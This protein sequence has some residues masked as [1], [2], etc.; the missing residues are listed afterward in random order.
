MT[1]DLTY[2]RYNDYKV[3]FCLRSTVHLILCDGVT[4]RVDGFIPDPDA[5]YC[6]LFL[7]GQ[8]AQTGRL[9]TLELSG[10]N[11]LYLHGG[12]LETDCIDAMH[13]GLR[14]CAVNAAQSIR[15]GSDANLTG[16][17]VTPSMIAKSLYIPDG[18]LR[19]DAI[20]IS[21]NGYMRG[22]SVTVD[23]DVSAN[24]RFEI[25]GGTI[26]VN[27][28][29]SVGNSLS[30][31]WTSPQDRYSFHSVQ[32]GTAYVPD[33]QELVDGEYIYSGTLNSE[34]FAH[35]AGRTLML[36][37]PHDPDE[38]CHHPAV[39]PTWDPETGV[40][41]DGCVEYWTCP[42]CGGYLAWSDY[43]QDLNYRDPSDTMFGNGIIVP[44]FYFD[45]EAF[46]DHET[47]VVT[48][49]M[50]QDA[51]VVIP[52]VVPESYCV[53]K[54]RG[55][56][57]T[58]ISWSAFQDNETVTS[59][60]I[61]DNVQHISFN[62]FTGRWIVEQLDSLDETDPEA[63]EAA[64]GEEIVITKRFLRL[65][66]VWLTPWAA[67][68]EEI[69]AVEDYM[70]SIRLTRDY[71]AGPEDAA[72][73]IPAGRAISTNLNG[74][75]ID[76]NLDSPRADGCVI[77]N[78]GELNIFGG[79]FYL[80]STTENG[81]TFY[82]TMN[83]H[84][85]RITGNTAGSQ[86]GGIL[87]NAILN[88]S[89]K[90]VVRDNSGR[91]GNNIYLRPAE[92]SRY[93]N[94]PGTLRQGAE[95]WVYTET[96]PTE[97]APLV[98][99]SGLSEFDNTAEHFFSDRSGWCAALTEDGEAA[100]VRSYRVSF[101][102]NGGSAEMRAVDVPR[103]SAYVLPACGFTA[104]LGYEF[105][106]WS[107]QIGGGAA[108]ELRP[109]DEIE[110][111]ANT[112]V[113]ALWA[114]RTSPFADVPADA[115]YIDAVCWAAENG[116]TAGTSE[117]TF[118]PGSACTRA[119]ILT[120][121]WRAAGSPAPDG[122]ESPFLDVSADAWY[123]EAVLWAWENG[124]TEGVDAESFAPDRACTRAQIVT[125]LWRL[126]GSPEPIST[127]TGFAD[128]PARAWYA[129]AVAW[130][131]ENGITAGTAPDAFSPGQICTRA[132]AVSFLYAWSR[133]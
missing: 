101:A 123:A 102:A 36:D 120:F 54:M 22:G 84:A 17:V 57:V 109:G 90:P 91:Y 41:T 50:G 29:F 2:A 110:V 75:T 126:E 6:G 118:S 15:A 88:V 58:S 65:T 49:Y 1:Q 45:E 34:D 55:R 103:G 112:T 125:F 117:T 4:L 19:T 100:L 33:G 52:N 13:L 68:Q 80:G 133:S 67:L 14:C 25:T 69:N 21:D 59:V 130:A 127:V 121:L 70:G 61:P 107:V 78:N 83:L 60:V 95:L 9:E 94:V 5:D 64:V 3:K 16:N 46:D 73:V 128:V 116:I 131:L 104:P 114:P 124:L 106:A 31:G 51:D 82:A 10:I 24:G 81:E 77:I 87:N 56:R 32:C 99:T 37:H 98:I 93:L 89:G 40:M 113:T 96:A 79:A 119:Q 44:Y 35:M 74:H 7:F 30:L 62:V 129:K 26:C 20:T 111:T 23:G 85:G 39:V 86:G 72:L 108:E 43:L 18:S 132:E 42:V 28:D 92:I 8:T 105:S 66:P 27:G 48:E 76:R 11:S 38:M 122:T 53:P 71:V 63:L 12:E 115:W 47:C 97:S